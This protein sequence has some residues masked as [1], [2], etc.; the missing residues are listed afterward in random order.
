MGSAFVEGPNDVQSEVKDVPDRKGGEWSSWLTVYGPTPAIS[1]A[2]SPSA[3]WLVFRLVTRLFP[4]FPVSPLTSPL[5]RTRHNE[6]TISIAYNDSTIPEGIY[7]TRKLVMNS[8]G[9]SLCHL[10]V[11]HLYPFIFSS[12]FH[13]LPHSHLHCTLIPILFILATDL[14]VEFLTGLLDRIYLSC[15]FSL[16]SSSI[17]LDIVSCS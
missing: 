9:F 6:E 4:S 1:L 14:G 2:G 11:S 8:H 16:I 15:T 5:A 13:D 10:L 17:D 7:D 3:W 12:S